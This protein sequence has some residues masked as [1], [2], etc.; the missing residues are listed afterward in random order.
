M[1]DEEFNNLV[2]GQVIEYMYPDLYHYPRNSWT[3]TSRLQNEIIDVVSGTGF[4]TTFTIYSA[5]HLM[6]VIPEIGDM[7][8][9][10]GTYEL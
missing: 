8:I 7:M 4:L 3:I 2:V 9:G 10:E 5:R 6:V 1:T